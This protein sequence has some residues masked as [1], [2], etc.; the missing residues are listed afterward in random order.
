MKTKSTLLALL[1]V[2]IFATLTSHRALAQWVTQNS[3]TTDSLSSV[4]FTDASTGYACGTTMVS[5]IILLKTTDGGTTWNNLNFNSP[6]FSVFFTDANNGY[7]AGVDT[8]YKTVN[9][10]ATWTKYPLGLGSTFVAFTVYFYNST[11]GYVSGFDYIA[12]TSTIFHTTDAGVSWIASTSG[13]TTAT[14]GSTCLFCT[15]ATTCYAVGWEG[16]HGIQKTTN[17]GVTWN[18]IY[19]PNERELTS[20]Y[21]TNTTTGF[22]AGGNNDSQ[23][24]Y[25]TTDGG[26][27][28]NEVY[29][30]NGTWINSLYFTSAT[31]G[32]AVGG[33]FGGGNTVIQTT[34]GG[35]TW[36]PM[37]TPTNKSLYCVHFPTANTGYAVGNTGTI[38]KYIFGVG[39]VEASKV[40]GVLVFPNPATDVVTLN[41]DNR[42]N[43]DLTLNIYNVIGELVRSVLLKQ[44]QQKINIGDLNNGI[45]MVEIKSKKCSGKQKLIIHR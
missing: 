41:I 17:G 13:A 11:V 21:F 28:W 36:N 15:N 23:N 1:F 31:T 8:I 12:G 20:V 40:N 42:N 44:N 38:I 19:N 10:G 22:A 14:S 18:N 32:Y 30:N 24:I 29:T 37:T 34:D 6:V 35:T 33:D 4:F 27:T 3:T 2:A 45:Y 16:T 7:I 9:A 26:S 43:A 5:T 39:I 25:R